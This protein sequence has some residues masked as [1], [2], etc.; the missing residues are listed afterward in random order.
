MDNGQR[1]MDDGRRTM[2][3][4]RRQQTTHFKSLLLYDIL[5]NHPQNNENGSENNLDIQ[6]P[7]LR[8]RS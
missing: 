3:D 7:K 2:D 1:M 8:I 4:G 6:P 5:P